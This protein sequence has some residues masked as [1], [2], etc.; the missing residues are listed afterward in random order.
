M[1]FGRKI[2]RLLEMMTIR[3]VNRKVFL[4][5]SFLFVRFDKIGDIDRRRRRIVLIFKARPLRRA[6][7]QGMHNLSV[8]LFT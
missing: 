8:L 3:F 5:F 1:Y 7:V 4:F 2:A 6:R